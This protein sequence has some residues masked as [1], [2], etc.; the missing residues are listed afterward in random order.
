MALRDELTGEMAD[1]L[2]R[3]VKVVGALHDADNAKLVWLLTQTETYQ[4]AALSLDGD[5]LDAIATRLY[6]D[7]DGETVLC[8]EWG[9]RTPTGDI[10]YRQ[11]IYEATRADRAGADRP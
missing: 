6:P 2:L 10:V 8:E 7:F 11:D 4:R 1:R 3:M 9:W 5:I